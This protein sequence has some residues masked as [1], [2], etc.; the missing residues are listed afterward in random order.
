MKLMFGLW[1]GAVAIS[2]RPLARRLAE[3]FLFPARRD[4][5][6]RDLARLHRPNRDDARS[7]S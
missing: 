3:L 4:A 1:F 2:P 6:N 7:F 5:L